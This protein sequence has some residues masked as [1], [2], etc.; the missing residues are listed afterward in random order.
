MLQQSAEIQWIEN[1][2]GKPRF[3]A[4]SVKFDTFELIEIGDHTTISSNTILLTHDYSLTNALRAVGEQLPT[5]VGVIRP[6]SIGN[7]CF[8]GMNVVVLPG[9]MVEDNVIVGA[10]SVIRGH[11][12]SNSVYIGNPAKRIMSIEEYQS[13]IKSKNYTMNID[14][15]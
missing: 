14:S 1:G 3:I 4:A 8:I 9:T 6:I 7:N 10:G 12:E 13:K 2:G 5:D 15:K 11:L